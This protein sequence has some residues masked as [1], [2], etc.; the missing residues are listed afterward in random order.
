VTLVTIATHSCFVKAQ[1]TATNT[2]GAMAEKRREARRL[3]YWDVPENS[4]SKFLIVWNLMIP[5][6]RLPGRSEPLPRSG[7]VEW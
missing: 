3:A 1:W 4:V 5:K 2:C 7:R 6:M